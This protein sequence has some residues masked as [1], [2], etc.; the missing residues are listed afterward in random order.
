MSA[1][2]VFTLQI[3]ERG[4][5][6]LDGAGGLVV[7]LPEPGATLAGTLA[8]TLGKAL[9]PRAQVQLLLGGPRLSVTCAEV[10]PLTAR[11]RRDVVQ[12]LV[13]EA[14]LPAGEQLGQTLVP[15]ALAEGG[16]VLWIGSYPREDLDPW[17]A[18]LQAAGASP[19][20]VLPWQCAFFAAVQPGP[21]SALYLVLEPGEA[22]LLFARGWNLRFV[23]SFSLP[24]DLDLQQPDAAALASLSRLVAEELT[25]LLPFLRQKHRGEPP[26][27]LA[28]AGLQA[29]AVAALEGLGLT[30]RAL[31]P[32]LTPFL[33]Q[34]AQAERERRDALDLLPEAIRDARKLGLF[35]TVV[36]ASVALT[37]LL[38]AGTK[39]LLLHHE[40]VLVQEALRA[41]SSAEQRLNLIR[42]AD[43]AARLRFGLLRV[44]RAEARQK[45]AVEQ[46]EQLGVRL[47]QVPEGVAVRSV[48][49]TQEPG[50]EVRHRFQVAGAATTGRRFSL[51]FLAGYYQHLQEHP[52]L[53]L[54]PLQ[55]VALEDQ[56]GPV[57]GQA[58][59]AFR[60]GGTAP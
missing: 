45:Q 42:D 14:G 57:K 4:A 60:L 13:R 33:L 31:A 58:V 35:R 49:I 11:E 56:A 41:E 47:L 18:A 17:L 2:R 36:R 43:D 53:H 34:G 6:L 27:T 48:E 25:L 28:I 32:E 23:R 20:R 37:L 46:L 24:G 5:R 51:G 21:S 19:V 44:R 9:P 10:P 55:E 7:A 1:S 26:S 15:D 54:E 38:G 40:R 39:A 22:R 50:D 8:G 29:S 12:R 16:Q 59:A 3:Q 52:G 30:L